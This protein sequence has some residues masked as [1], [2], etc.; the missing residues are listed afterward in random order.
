MTSPVR[1]GG[2][3]LLI[4]AALLIIATL[5][6]LGPLDHP[7]THD[8]A[9]WTF[10]V[11]FWL[12]TVAF[13]AA[14]ALLAASGITAGSTLGRAGFV[15]F[16]ALWLVGEGVF[17]P[18][19]QYLAPSQGVLLVS[20]ALTVLALVGLLLAGIDVAR[21]GV[22]HGAA[23]WGLIAAVVL[24]A[25]TGAVAGGTGNATTITVL[26][27]IS[28]IGLALVGLS[29]LMTRRTAAVTA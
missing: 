2:A 4:A 28:A 6:E 7:A 12:S 24:S 25:V 20:T 5:A 10:L 22:A 23:R 16:G 8:G 27:L 29:Y 21:R 15:G 1:R 18:V 26:H 14:G 3:A 19:G 13:A 11:L 17:Y 9:F